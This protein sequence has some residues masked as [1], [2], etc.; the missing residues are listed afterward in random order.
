[1]N[2]L[3]SK[4]KNEYKN[5]GILVVLKKACTF[6]FRFAW[7]RLGV[8]KQWHQD[9]WIFGKLFELLKG[10]ELSHNGMIF[11]FDNPCIQTKRKSRFLFGLGSY[12]RREILLAKKYLDINLPLIGL[13]GCVGVVACITDKIVTKK[14]IVVEANP[15]IIPL[16]EKNKKAND[17]KFEIVNKAIGY[18]NTVDFYLDDNFVAGSVHKK[19]PRK[20]SVR[21]ITLKELTKDFKKINLFADIEGAEIPLIDNEIDVISEKVSILII[22]FHPAING[23]NEVERV[24]ARLEKAGLQCVMSNGIDSVF[25]NSKIL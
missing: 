24:T 2:A 1:M 13:G 10:N 15:H 12:E 18:E 7:Y 5:E 19:T 4:I 14:H 3:I 8:K 21:G 17:C 16:L 23:K 22:E 6:P 9:R 25:I 20:I 11:S